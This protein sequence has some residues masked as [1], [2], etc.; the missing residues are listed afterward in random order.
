MCKGL[1][2]M[3]HNFRFKAN[4]NWFPRKE[5][6]KDYK[7]MK[8]RGF[9]DFLNDVP[10]QFK[11]PTLTMKLIEQLTYMHMNYGIRKRPL[12]EW[13]SKIMDMYNTELIETIEVKQKL[14]S[15]INE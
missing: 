6:I 5:A 9:F 7:L 2:V 15:L 8:E 11:S 10:D 13:A 12:G 4:Y 14:E 3:I 1:D